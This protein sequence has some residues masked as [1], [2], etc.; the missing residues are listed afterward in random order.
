MTEPA[1]DPAMPPRNI[2]PTTAICRATA[3]PPKSAVAYPVVVTNVGI[4]GVHLVTLLG[5]WAG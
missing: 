5:I 1:V 2:K 3:H 4:A